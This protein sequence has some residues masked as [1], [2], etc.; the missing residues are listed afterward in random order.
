MKQI[1]GLMTKE[2][3]KRCETQLGITLVVRDAAKQ[4]IVDKA[5]DPKYGAR[6]LR[7]KIQDDR[8]DEEKCYF[9]GA[10]EKVINFFNVSEITGNQRTDII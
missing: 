6:P 7:R 8:L 4:Y 3:A 10:E 1:V 2:L 9:S 5:Y